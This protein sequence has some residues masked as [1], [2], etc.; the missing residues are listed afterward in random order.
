MRLLTRLRDLVAKCGSLL[1]ILPTKSHSTRT[2]EMARDESVASTGVAQSTGC[3][4]TMS[5]PGRR[6]GHLPVKQLPFD[7]PRLFPRG[8]VLDEN[9][10]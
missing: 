1:C 4:L 7:L 3:R 2:R 5:D 10:I 6:L 8:I 9:P